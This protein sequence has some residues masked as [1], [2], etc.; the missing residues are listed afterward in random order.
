MQMQRNK[1]YACADFF[2]MQRLLHCVT[3]GANL[4]KFYQNGV[5]MT[6]MACIIFRRRRVISGRSL[7]A[8]S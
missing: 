6:G 8:S 2:F 3:V 5:Q 4:F 7:N 1:M